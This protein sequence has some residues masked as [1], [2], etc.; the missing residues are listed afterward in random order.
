MWYANSSVSF[1][2]GREVVKGLDWA[3]N[4]PCKNNNKS[5]KNFS[6]LPHFVPDTFNSELVSTIINPPFTAP[7]NTKTNTISSSLNTF[8][9]LMGFV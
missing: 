3:Y 6:F 2:K 9:D 8:W 1:H 5:G 7:L 4:S